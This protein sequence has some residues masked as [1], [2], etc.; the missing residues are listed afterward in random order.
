MQRLFKIFCFLCILL[1][2]NAFALESS[3]Q[4]HK[5][6][7]EK[8]YGY[9]L[10]LADEFLN[11]KAF[12]WQ[13]TYNRFENVNVN[14]LDKISGIWDE[15]GYDFSIQ[16]LDVG[17]GYRYYPRTYDKLLN[18][19]MLEV[20][21]GAS[22]NLAEHKLVFRPDFDRDDIYFAKQG[23]INPVFSIAIQKSFD[24]KSAMHIGLKH[25]PSFSEFGSFSSLYIGFNYRFG[26]QVYY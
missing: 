21:V 23:D 18:S 9:S 10:S 3:I 14:D 26:S 4:L 1:S 20:Q 24:R 2:A 6:G 13:F 19:I 8:S 15:A 17:V 16:T 11:Q 22:V 7:Q 5:V 12:I 25:Y